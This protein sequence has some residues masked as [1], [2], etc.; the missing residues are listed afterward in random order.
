MPF[1]QLHP[2]V[3][4]EVSCREKNL[5]HKNQEHLTKFMQQKAKI[6]DARSKGALFFIILKNL[7]VLSRF[8]SMI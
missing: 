2:I 1:D 5:W 8:K 7:Y 3:K 4:F 6:S